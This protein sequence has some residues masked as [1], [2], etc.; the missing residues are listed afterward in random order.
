[1]RLASLCK[2]LFPPFSDENTAVHA[3]LLRQY[4]PGYSLNL[5]GLDVVGAAKPRK[6]IYTHRLRS[7]D[8]HVVHGR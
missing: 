5:R 7:C 2:H 1:M 6:P 3:L 4:C 8:V